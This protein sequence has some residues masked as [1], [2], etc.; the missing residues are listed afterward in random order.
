MAAGRPEAP[1]V[2]SVSQLAR[3]TG[4]P[5]RRIRYYVSE[6]LLPLPIGRGRASHYTTAHLERLQQI[7]ALRESNLGLEEIRDRLG[8]VESVSSER[9]TPTAFPVTWQRWE[10]VPGVEIHAREDLDARTLSTVRVMVGAVR[11]VLE[12]GELP[13]VD[14]SEQDE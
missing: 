3:Q 12:N 7:I 9:E 4:V 10:I 8:E 11:H 1:D 14:W 2:M 13:A 5:A 6:R